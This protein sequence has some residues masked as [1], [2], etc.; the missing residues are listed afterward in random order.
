MD[1]KVVE[2]EDGFTVRPLSKEY[3]EATRDALVDV[4]IRENRLYSGLGVTK[5]EFWEYGSILFD[6]AK[7]EPWTAYIA[8]ENAT[9]KVVSFMFGCDLHADQIPESRYDALPAKVRTAIAF[10]DMAMKIFQQSPLF[11]HLQHPGLVWYGLHAG[12]VAGYEGR[13]D[14]TLSTR[15]GMAMVMNDIVP[16]GYVAVVGCATH[17]TTVERAFLRA[18]S[19]GGNHLVVGTAYFKDFE[20]NGEFPLKAITSPPFA[21]VSLSILPPYFQKF[22]SRL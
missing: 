7:L 6:R 4:W 20:E 8:V 2:Y 18:A 17:E 21:A 11:T 19:P 10:N 15:C 14:V 3:E 1:G 5:E 13:G 22:A 9:G 12:T 16:R